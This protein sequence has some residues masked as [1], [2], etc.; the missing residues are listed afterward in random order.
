MDEPDRPA[1][2]DTFE[3]R[4]E[5]VLAL[6]RRL[7]APD[8]CPWDREQTPRSLLPYLIEEAHEVAHALEAGDDRAAMDELGDLLLHLA[9]QIVIAEEEGRFDLAAVAGGLIAK[10]VR[11][12]PHVFAD[13]AYA[14]D[15]H[16]AL[17]ERMKRAE[18]AAPSAR[19]PS[20]LGEMPGGLPALVRAY[21]IQQKVAAIGFDWQEPGGA[22]EKVREELDETVAAGAEAGSSRLEEEFGDLLFAIVNWGRLLELHPHLALQRA[23]RKFEDRFRRM[24]ALAEE[25]GLELE[26]MELAELDALWDAVKAA[27][28]S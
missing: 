6:L 11:R 24:E 9:F 12:H 20:V 8:G 15:G 7:R 14:G 22:L 16:Q 18:K 27:E 10:M 23:N 28:P 19:P 21:R 25:R 4:F 17:W 5:G 2:P 26:A 3:P 13:A 1:D